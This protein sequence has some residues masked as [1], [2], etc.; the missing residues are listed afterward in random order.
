MRHDS[1]PQPTMYRW[2]PADYRQ[3]STMQ[4][5]FARDLLS[6]LRLRD[7]ERVLDIGCGDG[8][9]T[10]TIA[11]RVPHGAVVGVD[12]S[13]EMIRFAQQN[14]TE[15]D[16]VTFQVADA[17]CLPFANDFEWV[18]S[19]AALHW[20]HDHRPVLAS[21]A[22][23][24][25][26]R[27]RVL[28]QFGGEGNGGRLFD[29]A[30]DVVNAPRWRDYFRGFTFPWYFPSAEEYEPLV[31][32]T[33]LLPDRVEV[34]LREAMHQG[35]EGFVGWMR[36][37]WIPFLQHLPDDLRDDFIADVIDRYLVVCPMDA[38]GIARVPMMRLEVTA[39]K[40][41]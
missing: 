28:M 19:F 3:H 39:H 27:G 8:K 4:A 30:R 1:A 16:N 21:I 31:R 37:T 36:T 11:E 29:I 12:I 5:Q 25:K 35:R 6:L 7:D 40:P 15:L 26:P 38:D 13:L 34:V 33:G 32:G 22:R 10:A 14:F 2:N 41:C 23:A 24:L 9:I 20:I 17:A 18:M